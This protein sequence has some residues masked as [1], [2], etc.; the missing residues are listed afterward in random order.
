MGFAYVGHPLCALCCETSLQGH[1]T[2]RGAEQQ[3]EKLCQDRTNSYCLS[4]M[5]PAIEVTVHSQEP[6][7]WFLLGSKSGLLQSTKGMCKPDPSSSSWAQPGQE[8]LWQACT[9]T[10]L[11]S[12]WFRYSDGHCSGAGSW[13]SHRGGAGDGSRKPALLSPQS[14]CF[15]F[16]RSSSS[17]A[18]PWDAKGIISNRLICLIKPVEIRHFEL[19]VIQHGPHTVLRQAAW[20]E[21]TRFWKPRVA[22]REHLQLHLKPMVISTALVKL[23]CRCRHALKCTESA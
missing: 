22:A 4:L 15:L 1:S 18:H 14:Y 12:K 5:L 11:Q 16:A 10:T 7:T 21:A 17:A 23:H 8:K 6:D 13:G 2:M 20:K 3:G 9:G 19:A